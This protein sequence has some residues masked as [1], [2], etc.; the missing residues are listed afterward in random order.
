MPNWAMGQVTVTGKKEN[1]ASFVGRF[2]SNDEPSIIPGKK[3]F[4]RSF[5]DDYR[6]NVLANI[7]ESDDPE[8][9]AE[10]TFHVSFAWSANCCMLHGYP[11]RSNGECITLIDACVEDQVEVVIHTTEPGLCFEEEIHCTADG[12]ITDIEKDLSKAKCPHCG[13]FHTIGSFEDPEEL[14]CYECGEVGLV[15]CTDDEEEDE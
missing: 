7:A 2:V 3:Y 8:E 10:L 9:N 11:E 13:T 5:L 14:E 6:D 12:S 1:I 15:R 4:A